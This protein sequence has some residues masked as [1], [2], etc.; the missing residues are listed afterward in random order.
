MTGA[1]RDPVQVE[2]D[3]RLVGEDPAGPGPG[4]VGQGRG[5]Q[6]GLARAGRPRD[7]HQAVERK[8]GLLE[9]RREIHVGERWRQPR[10]APE[11]QLDPHAPGGSALRGVHPEPVDGGLVGVVHRQSGPDLGGRRRVAGGV[12][13]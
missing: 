10:K 1:I 5:E 2:L 11:R 3:R 13:Q 6:G 7:E 8:Q 12:V 4:A 9:L